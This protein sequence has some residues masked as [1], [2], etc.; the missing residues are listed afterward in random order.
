M[1]V[2]ARVR[3]RMAKVRMEVKD[4]AKAEEIGV[5]VAE[6]DMLAQLATVGAA[7]VREKETEA[8]GSRERLNGK[9]RETVRERRARASS[10]VPMVGVG[11]A[12]QIG[13]RRIIADR[14]SIHSPLES[15]ES[16]RGCVGFVL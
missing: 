6:K 16:L 12:R 2:R 5:K 14:V 8:K 4:E 11:G 1:T 7:K 9:A 3:E 10:T 15:A 13:Q